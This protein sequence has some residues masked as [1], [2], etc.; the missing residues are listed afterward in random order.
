MS[1]G[2]LGGTSVLVYRSSGRLHYP[3]TSSQFYGTAVVDLER[4]RDIPS[5]E[6][7]QDDTESED[8]HQEH[9]GRHEAI[10]EVI[11]ELSTNDR[12]D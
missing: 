11:I 12:S 9:V 4:D 6:E 2:H 10:R 7:R 1:G 5:V 3:S 8:G